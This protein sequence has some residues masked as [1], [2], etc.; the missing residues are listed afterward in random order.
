MVILDYIFK[1]F[2]RQNML[3]RRLVPLTLTLALCAVIFSV[4]AS[5][6]LDMN[7]GDWKV[8]MTTTMQGMPF[9]MPP[10]TYT[11]TQCVTKEDLAPLD[12]NKKDCVIKDQKINGNTFSWKVVCEDDSA[13]T[14]G[15]GQITYSGS[16]YSGTIN[17][18]MTDKREG[19]SITMLT[20][21]NG[22]YLGP[23]SDATKAEADKRKA[24]FRK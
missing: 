16:T 9:Q 20:R 14:E 4:T 6:G 18:S 12:K 13:K 19:M 1:L 7:E 2:R 23:C 17:T 10:Q 21:L 11:M 5:F 3:I 15:N 24:R 8:T 22:Q